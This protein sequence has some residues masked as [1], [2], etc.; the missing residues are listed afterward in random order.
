MATERV[1]SIGAIDDVR[2][3]TGW[4]PNSFIQLGVAGHVFT[5]QNRLFFTQ[6]FPDSLRFVP[7]QQT[8]ELDYTGFAVSGGVVL[9]PS[10]VLS[11]GASGRKGANLR[12][13]AGDT[14][15]ASARIPDRVGAGISF[16]G[17]PGAT[18]SAQVE[19]NLWSSLN[20]LGSAE[21]RAVDAWD[22]GGGIEATGPR[23][24]ERTVL[25][26]LGARYRT[27]PFVAAGGEVHELA[28]AGGL[29]VQ[30]SRNRAAFDVTVQHASRS[31]DA[32][33]SAGSIRERAYTLS[34]GLRVR[35]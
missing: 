6:T 31:T 3:A 2:L 18:I 29:G 19:R 10:R 12:A 13:R 34:F 25:L 23:I 24:I 8:S 14:L 27:L 17:I 15:V 32:S 7:V 21:A 33:G 11:L 28:F 30:F 26:R 1:K 5:G 22:M 35:P 9:H 4:E 16:A 20:G